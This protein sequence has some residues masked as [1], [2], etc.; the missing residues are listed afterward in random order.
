MKI[1]DV[2]YKIIKKIE[3]IIV[4][5]NSIISLFSWIPIIW[6]DRDWDWYYLAL[7]MEKKIR[8]MHSLMSRSKTSTHS[9]KDLRRMLIVANCLKRIMD[10]DYS[11]KMF[12]KHCNKWGKLEIEKGRIYRKKVETED[13]KI[14][15]IKEFKEIINH[16]DEMR[17]QDL[18]LFLRSMRHFLKWWD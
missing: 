4:F 17:K 10:D 9:R 13:D 5:I 15:E 6:N 7:I 3:P 11:D 8:K 16:E 18:E 14:K 2:K 12:E 1:H